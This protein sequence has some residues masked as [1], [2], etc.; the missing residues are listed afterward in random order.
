MGSARGFLH[1]MNQL[2]GIGFWQDKNT[3]ILPGLAV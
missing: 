1:A 3:F 2:T